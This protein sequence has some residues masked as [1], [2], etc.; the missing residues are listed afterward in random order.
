MAE[1][2]DHVPTAADAEAH[3][4]DDEVIPEASYM[5]SSLFWMAA[6]LALAALP[7]ATVAGKR[8]LGWVQEPWSWPFITLSVA[9][10]GG[11]GHVLRTLSAIKD[12]Q[13]WRRA[14]SAFDGLGWSFVYAAMFLTYVGSVGILGFTISSVL[15]MQALYFVSGLRGLRWSLTA[16]AVTVVIVL[17]FRVGLGIWFPLPPVMQLFPDWVGNSIG[18]FL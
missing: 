3:S 17:M 1:H 7:V 12:E 4:F 16:F 8:A 5:A 15:L 14:I 13:A 11:S 6:V 10:I 9:L 2:I 18:D